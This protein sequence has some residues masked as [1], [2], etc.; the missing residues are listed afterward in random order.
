MA[1]TLGNLQQPSTGWQ[2]EMRKEHGL[3][4]DNLSSNLS[5]ASS[6]LWDLRVIPNLSGFQFSPV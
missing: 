1:L 6:R 5:S 4:A 3:Q 2:P